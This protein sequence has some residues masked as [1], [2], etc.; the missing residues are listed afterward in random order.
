MAF[1]ANTGFTSY[2]ADVLDVYEDLVGELYFQ[3]VLVCVIDMEAGRD[4]MRIKLF[5][6]SGDERLQFSLSDLLIAI[7]N[8]RI[9]LYDMHSSASG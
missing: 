1:D 8:L 2:I 3:D 6:Q 7:E 9:R 5:G 4:A